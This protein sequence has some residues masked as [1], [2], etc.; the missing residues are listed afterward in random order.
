MSMSLGVQSKEIQNQINQLFSTILLEQQKINSIKEPEPDK[1][2]IVE[3]MLKEFEGV[4]GKGFFYNYLSSGEGHGPFTKLVDGSVKYDLINGI[5]VNL[6]GHSHPLT[7][8]AHL[9]AAT[10]DA[11]MCGNLLPYELAKQATESLM[12]TVKSSKL[13]NFWFAGSGSFANDT[14]LKI[15]WQKSAP[16]Y[17]LLAFEKAFAGRSIATQNITFNEAYR[18]GMPQSLEV[19]HV[20]HF[21]YNNPDGA[22][23]KTLMALNDA[24]DADP[25]GYCAIMLELVQGEAGFIYGTIDY[26]KAICEWAREKGIYIWFDEVQTFGRTHQLFA[27]QTFHLDE[28][29]DAVTIGKA[30]QTCGVLFSEELNPRP[31]LIA[32]TFNGSLVSLNMAN[33]TIRYLTEGNF[34]GDKGRIKELEDSFILRLNRLKKDKKN[35]IGYVGGIGTMISFEIGDSSKEVTIKFLK[36]LFNN[37][38][39]AFMAGSNPTRVRFL[40]PLSILDEQIDEIFSIIDKTLKEIY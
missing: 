38:I 29:A 30:F 13:K 28:Y 14:A 22:T 3:M 10:T 34:Y 31:G 18:E 6:L 16:K 21:D 37:G 25:D 12:A 11:V 40:L 20:P 19:T 5:G 24:W 8:K 1:S 7:I 17:K 27:F 15:I 4:R 39:I 2:H 32:G 33:K 23:D 9:E 36:R 35:K 26:Y